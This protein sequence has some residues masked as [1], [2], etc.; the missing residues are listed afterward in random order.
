MDTITTG[1]DGTAKSKELYL[2]RYEVRETQAP[3]GM[4]LNGETHTVELVYAGQEVAVTETSTSFYNERQKVEI[5]LIKSLEVDEAYGVGNNG[6]IFDVSFGLYAAE[7][8]TAADGTTIPADGLIE[9]IT[10]DENGH[11]KTISDLPMGSYY[12]QEIST[13]SAYLKDDTKYPV[14]FEYAG[15]ETALVSI[16]ANEAKP[17]KT[18]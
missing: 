18:T 8:L 6:E 13:N 12:V 11:G 17:L 16:T 1:A 9:V 15:Q 14:V 7:E 10:L 2:G 3:Y 4:V 5:D